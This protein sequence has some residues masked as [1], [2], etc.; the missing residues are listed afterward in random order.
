MTDWE[1]SKKEFINKLESADRAFEEIFRVD[2]DELVIQ[3]EERGILRN[4]QEDNRKI[5]DKIKRNEFS[6]SIVGLEKAGKSTLGNALIKS[7]VLPEDAQRCTYTTTEIRAGEEDV[8]EVRFYTREE[9]N[10]N[11]K[12]MLKE[13]EYPGDVDFF[14][15]SERAFSEYWDGVEADPARRNLFHTFDGDIIKDIGR[16]L[17][18]KEIIKP[19][20]GQAPKLFGKESWESGEFNEFKTYVTGISGKDADGSAIRKP[21]PYAVKNIVIRSTELGKMSHMVIYDV[22]GF[23]SPTELHKKQT[24]EMLK[25]SD[26]IIL[27]TNVGDRPNL[28]GPQLDM[29][30]KGHDA[31]GVN[32]SDKVFVFG[33][34]L[35]RAPD[36]ATGKTNLAALRNDAVNNHIARSERVIGGSARA[37][38]ETLG[39][40]SGNVASKVI[41]EWRPEN[42]N[43]VDCLHSKMKDYY[44]CDRFAVLQKRAETTLAGTRDKLG[45][46]LE[47]YRD[48]E[49]N[50][51]DA[52]AEVYMEIRDRLPEFVR[53]ALVI[54]GQHVTEVKNTQ[55]FSTALKEKINEVYPLVAEGHEE[56]IQNEEN[57]LAITAG[58]V[59]KTSTVDGN[60]RNILHV[61]FLENI[62]KQATRLTG[63]RQEA[64]RKDLITAFLKTMGMEPATT[65]QSELTASVNKL[66]DEMLLEGGKECDFNSLVERFADT[67]IEATILCTFGEE[68]R[69]DTVKE[70][71]PEL[72]SLSVYYNLPAKDDSPNGIDLKNIGS[73]SDVFFAK[74]LAHEGIASD[75]DSTEVKDNANYLMRLL[76]EHKGQILQG[77][78]IAADYFPVSKWAKLLVKAGVS[79]TQME[80]DE[81]IKGRYKFSN[82]F[83]NLVYADNW[84]KLL[85]EEKRNAIYKLVTSYADNK[86]DSESFSDVLEVFHERAK[87]ERCMETKEDMIRALDADIEILRDITKKSVINAIGL[88]RAFN[89]V[90]TKNVNLIRDHLQE[91]EGAKAFNAW[92]RSHAKELMPSRFTDIIENRAVNEKRRGI[93]NAVKSVLTDWKV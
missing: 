70:L 67:V 92:I 19:L 18:G 68:Q 81:T 76:E 15:M 6:V 9:F 73:D 38:L 2:N 28:T 31:Y 21:H 42:G 60:V 90:I 74:I 91:G 20:L 55:P 3:G 77:A 50:T 36:A 82:K 89:S 37:F 66:F 48:G 51:D 11:F 93:V 33:N 34:K 22:P 56:L 47:R 58:A 44:N 59:Y 24:E 41:E 75:E 53:E 61:R 14:T 8:A 88:E 54:T 12:R 80:S 5:L 4:L 25:E 62:V 69:R 71:L 35:D 87:A 85:P 17:A 27:V 49:L 10:K 86:G 72:V 79:L 7:M 43:G 46:L 52:A 40:I 83:E 29:L 13:L 23:D 45:E 63:E 26:A 64:L 1:E 30:R 16:M 32:L 78:S 39:K 65:Y 57:R 84:D